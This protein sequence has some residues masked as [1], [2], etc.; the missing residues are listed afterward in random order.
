MQTLREF[1]KLSLS[2]KTLTLD[3][4]TGIFK[5]SCQQIDFLKQGKF[6]CRK[7]IH[8]DKVILIRSISD[9]TQPPTSI[10]KIH[11]PNIKSCL[12]SIPVNI[13][14]SLTIYIVEIL[15]ELRNSK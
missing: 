1:G 10:T 15:A 11:D 14:M 12:L 4:L 2:L 7:D 5:L 8:F 6:E 3:K 13:Y 9:F